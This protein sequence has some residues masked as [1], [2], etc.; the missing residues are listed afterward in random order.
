VPADAFYEWQKLDAKTKQPFAIAMKDGKPYAFAG[1][2]EKWKD[3][4]AG[5]ELLTFTVITTDP[6]EVVQPMHDRM[7]V[8]IPERDYDRWLKADPDRPPIDLLRPYDANKMTAW[9]VDKAVGNVKNDSPELIEPASATAKQ[10]EDGND[11]SP[12]PLFS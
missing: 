6:N 1:L 4:K 5:T 10:A 8:I 2:W 9:K 12:G 3:S 7:P 11:E